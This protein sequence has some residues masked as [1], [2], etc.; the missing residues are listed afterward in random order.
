MKPTLLIGGVALLLIFTCAAFTPQAPESPT[1]LPPPRLD[2]KILPVP[3]AS[4]QGSIATRFPM[5]IVETDPADFPMP[6]TGGRIGNYPIRIIPPRD[7]DHPASS[8]RPRLTPAPRIPR[9]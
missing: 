2:V 6:V 7:P 4:P 9:R 5:V 1:P 8:S 3:G